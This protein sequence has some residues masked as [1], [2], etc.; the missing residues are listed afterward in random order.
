MKKKEII[1]I[2]EKAEDL[3]K[4]TKRRIKKMKEEFSKQLIIRLFP[5]EE[6]YDQMIAQMNI[7]FSALCEH[8]GI[9]FEGEASIAYIQNNF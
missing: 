4:E 1:I 7:P 5:N 8:H 6:G 3:E 9:A 2:Y